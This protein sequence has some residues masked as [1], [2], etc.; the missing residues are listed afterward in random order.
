MC[1]AIPAK[2]LKTDEQRQEALADIGAG[3]KKTI[4]VRLLPDVKVGD[5][6][7]I[8]A[9]FAISTVAKDDAEAARKLFDELADEQS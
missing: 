1:L 7:L 4:S 8:H 6:V 9:G 3:A 5:Y 2:I